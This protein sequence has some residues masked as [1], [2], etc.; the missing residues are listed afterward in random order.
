MKQPAA[1]EVSAG[2]LVHEIRLLRSAIESLSAH[3]EQARPSTFSKADRVKLER[4]LPAIADVFSDGE[5]FTSRELID[6][7][8][9]GLRMLLSGL[10]TKQVGRLFT[11]AD[12]TA[13]G[14]FKVQRVGSELNRTLWRVVA[15]GSP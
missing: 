9:P 14:G 15:S 6:H 3:M 1:A 7:P 4:L 5:F 13:I 12:G 8:A 11:R 10:S 2:D